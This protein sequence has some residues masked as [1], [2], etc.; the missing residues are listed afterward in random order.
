M[1]TSHLGWSSQVA[2][3]LATLS[4]GSIGLMVL[5][6][7]CWPFSLIRGALWGL[8]AAGFALGAVV[9]GNIFFLVPLAGMQLLALPG[10]ILVGGL[11]FFTARHLMSRTPNQQQYQAQA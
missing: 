8:M 10:L 11:A 6:T 7:V 3:T 2:S 9:L 5:F 4:A 1:L